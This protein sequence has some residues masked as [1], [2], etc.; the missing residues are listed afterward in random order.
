[1]IVGASLAG[2][3][4]AAALRELGYDGEL[5]IIGAEPYPPY[6][7]PPLSKELRIVDL[8]YDGLRATW[9]LGRRAVG[10]DAGRRAVRLDDGTLQTGDGLV[11]ATGACARPWPGRVPARGVFTLRSRDDALALRAELAPGRRLV[12][13]G[14]GFLGG[15]IAAAARR[16]GLTVTLVEAAD[17]P[18]RGALGAEAGAFLAGLHRDAGVDLRTGRTLRAFQG[19]DR[20]TAVTLDDG[21]TIP[22]DLSVIALGAVAATEWL[23]GSGL[24]L[25]SGLRCDER[26]RVLRADGG[27]APGI[28]AVGD[29]VRWPHPLAGGNLISLGHWTNAVEQAA[30]AAHNLLHPHDARPYT[31]VPSFWSDLYG[32]KIRSIGLP[33]LADEVRVAES[34]PAA[35]RLEAA[36]L[37]DGRL[38]GAV[39]VN[40]VAR[41]A[42][43]RRELHAGLTA[44]VTR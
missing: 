40:R 29:V 42:P 43:Y 34:D 6:D 25:D 13:I 18:L 17:Q 26:L 22:A 19:T 37:R 38:I 3:R 16:R 39:T 9:R 1:M 15:E 31:G 10:L 27:P 20:L 8:P 7:R 35:R 4:T 21:S 33:A 14:A 24:L 44:V 36:Y 2:P 28:V 11:I 30:T 32:A 12:V 23:A 5:T 41:L